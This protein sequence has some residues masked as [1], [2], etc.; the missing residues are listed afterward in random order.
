MGCTRPVFDRGILPFKQMIGQSGVVV[1]P[2][3][4]ISFGSSGAINHTAGL[5]D[6]GLIIAVNTDPESAIFGVADYG[7]VGDMDE[8]CDL[9]IEALK[10]RG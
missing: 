2:K 3:L 10:A 6:S 1:K 8:V 5:K 9:M 4:F 7:I